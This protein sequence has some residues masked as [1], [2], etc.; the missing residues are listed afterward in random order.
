MKCECSAAHARVVA[1]APMW[2]LR[3]FTRFQTNVGN[4]ET[5][6]IE[7]IGIFYQ[8]NNS[9]DEIL[10]KDLFP[11]SDSFNPGLIKRQKTCDVLLIANGLARED[12][13]DCW[14]DFIVPRTAL[15]RPRYRA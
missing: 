3:N 5:T 15:D 1:A 9:L 6:R 13:Q 11:F 7:Y 10:A 14:G 8:R 12:L 4:V 2:T